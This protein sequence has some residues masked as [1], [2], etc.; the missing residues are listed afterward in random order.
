MDALVWLFAQRINIINFYLDGSKLCQYARNIM[1]TPCVWQLINW[2]SIFELRH[3][4]VSLINGAPECEDQILMRDEAVVEE[5]LVHRSSVVRNLKFIDCRS[6]N[7]LDCDAFFAIELFC[8]IPCHHWQ[9]W[10]LHPF[11]CTRSF[12]NACSFYLKSSLVFNFER[13]SLS[14]AFV[15]EPSRTGRAFDAWVFVSF[16]A[17]C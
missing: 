14:L 2:I 6:N 12:K 10:L 13:I 11:C 17:L 15:C 4:T 1:F 16:L 7:M 5:C 9:R 8:C 3:L